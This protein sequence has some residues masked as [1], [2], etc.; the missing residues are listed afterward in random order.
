MF[1]SVS[2][3]LHLLLADYFVTKCKC[4]HTALI[5]LDIKVCPKYAKCDYK[6]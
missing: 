2:V 6:A 3:G 1:K 4:H 5:K